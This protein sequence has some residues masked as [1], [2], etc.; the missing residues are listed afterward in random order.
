MIF[1][2]VSLHFPPVDIDSC[3][4]CAT[5]IRTPSCYGGARG[6]LP[7][8]D[9]GNGNQKHDQGLRGPG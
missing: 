4:G 9:D 2:F 3:Y 6:D 7:S 5:M 1:R 8:Y